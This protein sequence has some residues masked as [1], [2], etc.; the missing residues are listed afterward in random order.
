[1]DAH[2]EFQF[3]AKRYLDELE[4]ARSKLDAVRASLAQCYDWLERLA[5]EQPELDWLEGHDASLAAEDCVALQERYSGAANVC[6]FLGDD[7]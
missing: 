2:K 6:E 3:F 5:T 7:N 1:M 4:E